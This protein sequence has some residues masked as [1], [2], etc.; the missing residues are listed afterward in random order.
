MSS[1][2]QKAITKIL[3]FHSK[4]KGVSV[5]ESS[6]LRT[7][8]GRESW[9]LIKEVVS[10][11]NRPEIIDDGNEIKN[12]KDEISTLLASADADDMTISN[13]VNKVHLANKEAEKYRMFFESCSCLY[14]EGVEFMTKTEI[15]EAIKK[16]V[17]RLEA[18]HD[19]P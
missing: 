4:W 17:K 8:R 3:S 19:R 18:D 14:A 7:K 11:I 5:N 10:D 16:E 15:Y 6:T 9:K 12:L 13:L 2:R 1:K